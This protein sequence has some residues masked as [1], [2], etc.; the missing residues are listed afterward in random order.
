MLPRL[1]A[2][3]CAALWGLSLSA[4]PQTPNPPQSGATALDREIDAYLASLHVK[5][6]RWEDGTPHSRQFF[7]QG[8]RVKVIAA[9]SI[10]VVAYLESTDDPLRIQLWFFNQGD[11]PFDVLPETFSLSVQQPTS[12]P[13]PYVSPQQ[14]KK[15]I[16]S[17]AT[18][19]AVAEALSSVGRAYSGTSTTNTTGTVSVSDAR[20]GR[21]YGTY[22]ERATTYDHA[23]NERLSAARLSAI[24]ASAEDLNIRQLTGV[25]LANTVFGGQDYFGGVHFKRDKRATLLLLRVPIANTIFEFPLDIPMTGTRDATKVGVWLAA[26]N[27]NSNHSRNARDSAT[28]LKKRLSRFSVVRFTNDP[29]TAAVTLVVV[30]RGHGAA[31]FEQRFDAATGIDAA[32]ISRVVERPPDNADWVSVALQVGEVTQEFVGSALRAQ[33]RNSEPSFEKCADAI[34]A[35]LFGWL[36]ANEPV[37]RAAQ[38]AGRK[39]GRN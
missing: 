33:S 28:H 30:G 8:H 35:D 1:L 22:T 4:T 19:A 21:A 9:N 13:L 11:R 20:G 29:R 2:G 18:W 14:I 24:A 7:F 34:A 16:E 37:V 25:I 26:P 27:N 31:A 6:V 38:E 36:N 5:T 3:F 32:R 39:P 12:K 15:R 10:A 23:A 17:E